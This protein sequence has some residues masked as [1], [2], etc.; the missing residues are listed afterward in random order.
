MSGIIRKSVFAKTETK[1]SF[2]VTTKLISV[3]VCAT[4]IVQSLYFLNTKCQASSYLLCTDWVVSDLV[5][6]PEDRFSRLS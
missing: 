5:R 2:E 1:I 6:N 4:Q 3:S